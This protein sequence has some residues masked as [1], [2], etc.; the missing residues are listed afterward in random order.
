MGKR[1][2]PN[3]SDSGFSVPRAFKLDH[4]QFVKPILFPKSSN[5]FSFILGTNSYYPREEKAENGKMEFS[6][7]E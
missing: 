3:P 5:F 6:Q 7:P 1:S 4:L 2:S